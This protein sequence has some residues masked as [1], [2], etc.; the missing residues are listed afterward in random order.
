[1]APFGVGLCPAEPDVM[2]LAPAGAVLGEL[3]GVALGEPVVGPLGELVVGPLGA[4]VVGPLDA[5]GV[6]APLLAGAPPLAG[7]AAALGA[8]AF[9]GA[10]LSSASAMQEPKK[11]TAS[12]PVTYRR[13][14]ILRPSNAFIRFSF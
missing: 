14:K 9:L 1:M 12:I 6:A 5:P 10:G 2:G 11:S 8:G 13:E 3:A 4:P 7:G